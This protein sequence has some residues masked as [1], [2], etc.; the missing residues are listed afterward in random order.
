MK[1][2][3]STIIFLSFLAIVQAADFTGVKIYINPGH[4]GW[5]ANDRNIQTINFAMG[6]TLGF[7]E[8]KSNLTKGLYLRDLLQSAN[9]TVYMSRT[10]NRTEDDRV[11]SQIAAE[12]N[13]NGVDAFLSIHSNAVGSNVG[14]NYLLLLFHGR[15]NAPKY[16]Q[17]VTQA[18]AAWPRLLSNKLNVW[19]HYTTASN[20]RGDSTFYGTYG[21]GVL[22]PLTVPG[23][24]SEGS[25]HDYQPE[26]HRLLNPDFCK[27]ESMNFY[28]FYCDYFQ[29]DL[30]TTGIIAGFVKG[31][32]ETINNTKYVYKAGTDDRWLPLNGA[33]V[34]LMNAAGDSLTQYVVDTL[35]NGIFSFRDLVPGSYRLRITHKDHT[36]KDTLVTVTAATTT[37]AKMMLVNPTIVIAKDTTP[38]YP[39]P[40]QEAGIAA[41][42]YYKF[43]TAT[44]ATPDWLNQNQ[45]KK[46][47]YR[48]EKYYVLT[49]EPKILVVNAVNNTL[50]SEMKL[51]NIAGGVNIISDIAFTSDGYLLACNKDTVSLPELK[52]R[53]FK[54]YTWD[55]DLTDPKLLFQTQQQGNWGNGVMGETFAVSGPRWK[56]KIYTPSVTT[57]TTKAIRIVGLLYEE[58]ISAIGYKYMMDAVNY[59]EALWGKQLK[60][61]VSPTG[62]DHIYL[63]SE[64]V[65]PTEFQFD[66]GK[67]DR[68]PLVNKGVFTEKSGYTLQPFSSGSFYFRH[69]K[70]VFMTT[71]V[72]A[73]DSTAAGVVLF[74]I[75]EGLNKAVKISDK[76]PE[77]GLGATKS[78]FMTTAAKVT[79]YDIEV[80][81][82]AK[83]QGVGRYKTI[84]PTATANIYASE[85][86]AS[87]PTCDCPLTGLNVDFFLN[88]NAKSVTL[89]VLKDENVVKQFELGALNKGKNNF[90]GS[91]EELTDG[92]YRWSI[93]ATT[94]AVDRPVKFSD[95]TQPQMQFYSPRGVAID[96]S[97]ESPYFGRIYASETL[98]G[99]VTNRT[100]KDGIYIL[101][102]ALQD[103]TNQGSNAFSGG[104]T[105][106]GASSPM[107]LSVA[108][109]GD[110][111][112]TDWSDTNSGIWVMN[113][114]A[115][116]ANFKP[117][118]SGLT[119]ATS[120]LS[121]LNG[122]NV[123]G[124]I[125]HCW[126]TGTG[127]N[128][129]LYTFDQD[130]VD[131]T[132]T[133]TGNLLQYNIGTLQTPWQQAPS[134]VVYNDGLNG[135]LQQNFNSSIAPD[136]RGGWWISQ[137]RGEDAAT[138]P[139]LIH[140]GTNGLQNYNSGKTPLLIGNSNTGGMAVNYEGNVIAMGCKDEVRVFSIT[141]DAN[142]VPSLTLLHSIKP[143]MGTNSAGLAY[144]RA[145]NLYVISN[146]SERLGVW[147]MP[148]IENTF[149]TLSPSNQRIIVSHF[150]GLKEPKT[151]TVRVY[152]NPAQDVVNIQSDEN[153]QSI[154]LYDLRGRLIKSE[155][156]DIQK[157]E[158]NIIDLKKGIYLLKIKT[159][160]STGTVRLM[161]K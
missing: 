39:L 118:F 30:P 144:D 36:A 161:K 88:E 24:L 22:T 18:T 59:T 35:Y 102:A 64:K 85:L 155:V 73:P 146:T 115:P 114:A 5:D 40:A 57:G 119:R 48:N 132:A 87:I 82:L 37:Y 104:V 76:L 23:F 55:D 20:I 106:G 17:S 126:V 105:W 60:F 61:H 79:G 34:K 123:H 90:S 158:M 71:P 109:N 21:L 33:W 127:E 152:P 142:N 147:A 81:V 28:R 3:I 9:A 53:Y 143:A 93:T 100:T 77:A 4:G 94:D 50:L 113:P 101:N 99:T 74:D 2:I 98:S 38:D 49:N 111:Y 69:A 110:V 130:Y 157:Y 51:T 7:W 6:D 54:V 120:G 145:G 95:N 83:N 65:L 149:T 68:D 44:T 125:S 124:S 129:K 133:N 47:L 140:V 148:K 45:I 80:M 8:S 92:E 96:N 42:P 156:T 151:S 84:A 131:A 52:S 63:D 10:Q 62:P 58:N 122:V 139:S 25:F 67:P 128:T 107:R 66:W 78:D 116:S 159:N 75:T 91:L 153:I 27:L 141:Y 72:C 135:N 97:F 16:L 56:C 160:G 103:V 112:L 11:L 136:G 32:D 26:T 134:A 86:M 117:V 14:T 19:T 150:S 1:K 121:S 29:R 154:E 15:D 12:A 89:K 31:K 108:E 13:A 70:R 46:V 137:Y 41:L 138:I 43:G